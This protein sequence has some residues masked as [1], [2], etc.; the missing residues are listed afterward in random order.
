MEAGSDIDQSYTH[1]LVSP[2]ISRL[3]I[4]K[5]AGL[6]FSTEAK[7]IKKIF[8]KTTVFP[9]HNEGNG[10]FFQQN[11]DSVKTHEKEALA[12]KNQT[13]NNKQNS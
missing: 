7:T 13:T 8:Y 1:S 10:V 11:N 9:N 3:A 2:E 5:Q 12:L 4:V 6:K